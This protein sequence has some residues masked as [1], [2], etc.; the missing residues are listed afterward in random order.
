MSDPDLV[1]LDNNI[2]NPLVDRPDGPLTLDLLIDAYRSGAIRVVGTLS[3]EEEILAAARR[4]PNKYASM[5]RIYN[6][7]IGRPH[8]PSA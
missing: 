8:P 7:V 4:Q 1:F 2:Y 6:R 3:L 5:R